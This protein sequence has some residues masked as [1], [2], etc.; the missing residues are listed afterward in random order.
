MGAGD[1]RQR[2][3]V[4]SPETDQRILACAGIGAAHLAIRPGR[5]GDMAMVVAQ[6]P[7]KNTSTAQLKREIRVAQPPPAGRIRFRV[8]SPQAFVAPSARPLF[9]KPGA[10]LRLSSGRA[11]R[12]RPPLM[13]NAPHENPPPPCST[14]Q[15][16]GAAVMR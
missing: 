5:D 4:V 14:S 7:P 11:C 10:A 15:T 1:L 3:S 2:Y 9:R 13:C 8:P 6:K 16:H 12:T